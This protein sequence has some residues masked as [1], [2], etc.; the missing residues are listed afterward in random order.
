[1]DKLKFSE[2][3]SNQNQINIE[4]TTNIE[5]LD[6]KGFYVVKERFGS[7]SKEIGLRLNFEE[8]LKHSHKLSSPI[9]QKFI[10]GTEISADVWIIPEVYK[11][12]VLRYRTV[13]QDG[14][15]QIT[16]IFKN[17]QFENQLLDLALQLEISGPAVIQ[18]IIDSE[19]NL[20]IVECNP[21][22][23]GASTASNA[24]GS[25]VLRKMILYSLKGEAGISVSKVEEI[26]ELTQARVAMD[27]LKYDFDL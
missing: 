12:I 16:R 26:R 9:F 7:G 22:F 4:T 15:S 20:H 1:L 23:G 17:S 8:A 21:R 24:A 14:E 25:R 19:N 6:Q 3:L 5:S 11:S 10:E 18:A 27:I 2:F 13:I